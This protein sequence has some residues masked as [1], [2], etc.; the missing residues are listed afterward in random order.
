MSAPAYKLTGQQRIIGWRKV[1]RENPRAFVEAK[2]RIPDVMGKEVQFKYNWAQRTFSAIKQEIHAA[3]IPL[4]LW[5]GKWRRAGISSSESAEDFSTS[6]GRD[7][8]K[9]GILAHQEERAEQILAN[10]KYFYELLRT[11][12]P[13]LMAKLKKD[14]LSGIKWERGS[15]Q[16]LIGSAEN[17]V[18]IRGDGLQGVHISE[19]AHFF[20]KFIRV[21]EEVCPVVPPLAGS[22]IVIES[23]GTL[24]GSA[25]HQHYYDAVKLEDW[26]NG[27]RGKNE[28]IRVFLC[29]LDS[30]DERLPVKD[31]RE[32]AELCE[33]I[34]FSEPRLAE[35]NAYYKLTP[36]QIKVS[37][38][39]YHYQSKNDFD[40]FTREFPYT[41]AEM[42][43]AGG[44]SFYGAFELGKAKPQ[45]P[46]AQYIL[47]PEHLNMIFEDFSQLR[48]VDQL[49]PYGNRPS[50][51]VWN[52]PKPG[53]KF[54]LGS[55]HSLGDPTS[56]YSSG[57][58][59]NVHSREQMCTYHG[60]L[61]PDESA[62]IN[63]SLG[64][65]YNRAVCAPE[66]N[67]AGGGS[68]VLNYM[69]RLGYHNIYVWRIRDGIMGIEHSRKLGWWTNSRSRPMMLSH[70]RQL[71][72]DSV[73][74]RLGPG[75]ENMFRDIDQLAEMRTFGTNP[76]TGIPEANAN[77][78]DDRVIGDA[79]V[80]QICDDEV[81]LTK[82]D[83][84]HSIHRHDDMKRLISDGEMAARIKD[85]SKVVDSM[86]NPN[87]MLNRNK[88]EI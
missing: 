47:D 15:G 68:E 5:G 82:N 61:R 3:G 58:L 32:F 13:E 60:R 72:L 65:I 20:S 63:V 41:E 55:D 43:S 59:R 49:D 8:A 70:H 78:Y 45:T 56:D 71:F 73:N 84:I 9:L 31:A 39:M 34:R 40:Y 6:F 88:F 83:L 44:A 42:W 69:Q 37:W 27:K 51:K 28:F 57:S 24:M 76:E 66:T 35:K 30:P 25:P 86:F 74:G 67:P 36:E 2:L 10:Y 21:M 81:Y 4:R 48:R 79:I 26:R 77:C 75:S 29:W 16:V 54:A 17:P 7:F 50:I 12:S 14:N 80:N 19:G 46:I 85:P 53:Q 33:L 64:R 1:A 22:K 52:Y 38:R 87:S 62:H 18:K 23:T 11:H